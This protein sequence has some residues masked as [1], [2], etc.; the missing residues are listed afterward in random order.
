MT[1]AAVPPIAELVAPGSWRA[2]DCIADLHLD[3]AHP[4]TLAALEAYLARTQADAVCILGDLFEVWVGDDAIGEP[5]SFEGAVCAL[6]RAAALR[7]PLWFMHGNRDFLIGA[8]FARATGITLL[9]D[10][11]VL[12]LGGAR[13]LLSHGDALCVDDAPYQR[14]R[15]MVRAPDWQARLLAQPLAARRAQARAIR[16]ESEARKHAA[17]TWA[18]VDTA[19]ALAWLR[20]AHAPALVHGHTHRPAD[21]VLA[22]GCTRH[23]LTDWDLD[24]PPRRAG[25]LRLRAQGAER[26][27]PE[28]A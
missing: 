21:H 24:A 28:A 27:A 3:A 14:F 5:G 1:A 16:S 25:V 2:V 22:P 11:T 6:L 9:A 7:R 12:V 20:A 4:A 13:W 10:P 26:I 19:A 23:V 18:D 8:G 17:T 15:A